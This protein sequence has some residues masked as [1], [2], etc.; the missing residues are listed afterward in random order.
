MV[1]LVVDTSSSNLVVGLIN[2]NKRDGF[3]GDSNAKKHN[4]QIIN[5]IDEILK[6]NDLDIQNVDYLGVVTG[7]G[8]FT[9]IRVGVATINALALALS[10]KVIEI[11]ALEV[12]RE[13]KLDEDIVA[14]IDA[15]HNNYYTACFIGDKVEYKFLNKEEIEELRLTKVYQQSYSLDN[16]LSVFSKKIFQEELKV[17]AKPFYLKDSSAIAKL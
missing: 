5:V 8:S 7:P 1:G 17:S 4:S 15:R 16:L 11:T 3:I 14:L 10:K 9:G 6:S 13:S 12:L 2:N